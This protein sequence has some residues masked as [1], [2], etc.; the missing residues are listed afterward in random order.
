[1]SL[2]KIF[3]KNGMYIKNRLFYTPMNIVTIVGLLAAA[4]T[5]FS[6]LPQAIKSWKSRHTGDISLPMYILLVSGV[7]L[8]LVYGI[9]L[10]DL[11][12]ILANSV[13]LIFTIPIL[14][15]KLKLG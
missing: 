8:W 12:I 11:P 9:L 10:K 7:A 13:T 2:F 14:I 15:L 5:T 1:M 3:Q 6:F 4:G